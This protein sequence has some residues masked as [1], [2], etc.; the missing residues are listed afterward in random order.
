MRRRTLRRGYWAAY[1]LW[2]VRDEPKLP[3]WSLDEVTALQTR[4]VRAVAAHAYDS[5]PSYREVMDAARLHPRDIRTADDFAYLP[6]LSGGEIARD[7]RRFLSRRHT[8]GRALELRSSG[9]SG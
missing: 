5:V 2:H 7:P 6:A 9:T 4:R 8:N 1:T 3:C